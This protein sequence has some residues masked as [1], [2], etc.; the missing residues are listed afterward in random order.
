MT[1]RATC[2]GTF[3]F[4]VHQ[5]ASFIYLIY[6]AFL[7][8]KAQKAATLQSQKKSVWANFSGALNCSAPTFILSVQLQY[9]VFGSFP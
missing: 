4:T 2:T 5:S 1:S 3:T 9:C 6:P 8:E 7:H